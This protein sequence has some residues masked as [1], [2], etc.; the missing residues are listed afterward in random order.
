MKN[1]KSAIEEKNEK[2][3]EIVCLSE[4]KDNS[5]SVTDIEN[6]VNE[7]L[8]IKGDGFIVSSGVWEYGGRLYINLSK[9]NNYNRFSLVKY[10]AKEGI[11]Q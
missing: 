2:I 5:M 11:K 9:T 7:V 8:A 10:M 1:K 6:W 4:K 3:F